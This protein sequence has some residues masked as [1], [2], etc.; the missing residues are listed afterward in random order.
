MWTESSDK[1]RLGALCMLCIPDSLR[2]WDLCLAF[3]LIAIC[4]SSI[5][6]NLARYLFNP[7]VH[8]YDDLARFFILIYAWSTAMPRILRLPV[9]EVCIQANGALHTP[10]LLTLGLS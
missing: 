3:R 1:E 5:V 6:H 2:A 8:E 9:H 4:M 10:E 7:E